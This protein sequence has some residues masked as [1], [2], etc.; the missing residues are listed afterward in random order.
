MTIAIQLTPHIFSRYHSMLTYLSDRSFEIFK[1]PEQDWRMLY[2]YLFRYYIVISEIQFGL[3]ILIPRGIGR[4]SRRKMIEF[5]QKLGDW[6]LIT[7]I[8]TYNAHQSTSHPLLDQS[9]FPQLGSTLWHRMRVYGRVGCQSNAIDL[10]EENL[11]QFSDCDPC[12]ICL[13][14]F[15]EVGRCVITL[16]CH[17]HHR[18]HYHC[19]K[20]SSLLLPLSFFFSFFFQNKETC[21]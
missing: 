1:N 12:S 3:Q 4:R 15:D 7:T 11:K 9:F 20:V 2:R 6:Y 5:A 10:D 17:P 18:L 21:L 16:P 8:D 14:E 19:L 13:D